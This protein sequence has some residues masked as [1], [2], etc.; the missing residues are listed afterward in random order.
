MNNNFANCLAYGVPPREERILAMLHC[1]KSL[2]FETAEL[3]VT[4]PFNSFKYPRYNSL[5]YTPYKKNTYPKNHEVYQ[6][7]P[8]F[9][10][11]PKINKKR[12]KMPKTHSQN[13]KP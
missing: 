2:K 5:N 9:F 3:M 8:I 10:P 6:F 7:L 1:N 13:P 11:Q 4:D 12:A